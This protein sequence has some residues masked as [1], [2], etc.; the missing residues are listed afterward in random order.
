MAAHIRTLQRR[1][2]AVHRGHGGGRWRYP[3]ALRAEIVTVTR[4]GRAAGRSLRRLARDLGV[5]APTLTHWLRS[6]R[7]GR[8]RRVTVVPSPS[9][10]RP[11]APCPVLVT[12]HGVRVEGLDLVALVTVLRSL[13]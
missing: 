2:R 6:R 8:V 11:A 12:P 4:A 9:P 13:G 5:S 3:A 7:R 10:A 1:I